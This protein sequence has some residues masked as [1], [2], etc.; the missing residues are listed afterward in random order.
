MHKIQKGRRSQN[1]RL[2]I[3]VEKYIRRCYTPHDNHYCF[4]NYLL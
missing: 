4:S 3:T 2:T 1:E